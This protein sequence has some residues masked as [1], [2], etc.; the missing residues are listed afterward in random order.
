M[1]Y[2]NAITKI[3]SIVRMYLWLIFYLKNN[4][5]PKIEELY[6]KKNREYI[7]EYSVF[8]DNSKE[9]IK[10]HKIAFKQKQKKMKEGMLAQILI[11]NWIG[12]ESLKRGD[13][14]GLDCR[15]KDNSII[16]ELKNK[17]NTVKGS[18]IKK[19]L[20]P[21]LINY[22]KKNPLTRCIWGIV[23]PK[24]TNKKLNKTIT[25]NG[26]EIEKIQG[27]ELFKLV[28]SIGNIDYSTRMINIVRKFIK[29]F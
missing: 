20:L 23:N 8:G 15:R 16:L 10:L 7:H 25:F 13:P 19:S 11:G 12:W 27:F 6:N 5:F 2:N 1:K 26:Y 24:P 4:V 9:S 22:K 29:K 28:F 3:Q 21:T 14:I 17:Y 18:D